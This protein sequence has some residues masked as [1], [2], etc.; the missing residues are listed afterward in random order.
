MANRNP[1]YVND[2]ANSIIRDTITQPERA[3]AVTPNDS[4]TFPEPSTL[5]V[6]GTGTVSVETAGG[7]VVTFSGVLGW[8]PV[9]VVKVRATGTTATGIIR[10]Y[11]V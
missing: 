5:Y 3:A 4:T 2:G 7:D 8:F 6:A 9:K 11:N 10:L 1:L